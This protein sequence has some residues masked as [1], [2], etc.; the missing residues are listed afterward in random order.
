MRRL[1][2]GVVELAV[3]DAGAR[4]HA[5][6]FAGH[7]RGAVA[8]AVLVAERALEHIAHDLHVAVAVGAEAG[9]GCDAVFIDDAQVAHAH[10]GRVDIVG[11]RET[12]EALE[13]AVVGVTAVFGLAQSE[14]GG[15]CLSMDGL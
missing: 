10:V 5:L 4:A 9:A 11:K 1:V 7:D 14:H 15:A 13:P 8:D 12:V 3:R 2:G 6:H